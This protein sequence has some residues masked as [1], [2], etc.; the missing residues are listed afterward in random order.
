MALLDI[1]QRTGWL[2]LTVIVGHIILI[3]TQVNSRRGVPLLEAVTFELFAGVQRVTTGAVTSIESAWQDYFALQQIRRENEQLTAEVE[4]LRVSLQQERALAA[5]THTLQQLLDL[6]SRTALATTGAEI[7]G[8]SASPDFR[9]VT[10]NKG[11]RDGLKPDMSVIAPAGVVGR[12]IMPT[13]DAAKVQL[14]IDRNA[15]AGAL[16]E[17]SRAQG[18]VVGTGTDRLRMDYVST[19]ADIKVG[20]RVV[21]SGIDGI[22]PKGFV[23]GQIESIQKGPDSPTIVVR[24]AVPFGSIEAVL[25][26]LTP[27]PPASSVAEPEE[28]PAAATPPP[29][30]D[31]PAAAKP[32]APTTRKPTPEP[33]PTPDEAAPEPDTDSTTPASGAEAR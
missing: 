13:L 27:P 3:S 15:A 28:R 31:R 24:P 30:V 18:I 16:D 8:G 17:R 23:I 12:V 9:T 1:R 32:A 2:F 11:T 33:P 25:V 6:H 26:V 14:L 21:T 10:L 4:R 22:Y 5:Q 19:S 29:A 7:I 20:D